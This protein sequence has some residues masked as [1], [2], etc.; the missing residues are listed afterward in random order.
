VD[1]NADGRAELAAGAYAENAG[2]GSLWLF[3]T[4]ASG[5]TA[6][7]ST[8]FGSTSLGGPSGLAYFGEELAH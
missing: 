5:I 3:K 2:A 1:S 7:G 8:T 6:T 4:G